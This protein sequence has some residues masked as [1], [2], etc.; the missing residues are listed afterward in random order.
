M[1]GPLFTKELLEMARRRRFF[2]VRVLIGIALLAGWWMG[3]GGRS[4][5]IEYRNIG[6]LSAIG[7]QLFRSWAYF[8]LW[9]VVALTPLLVGGLIAGEKDGRT[10][11]T[12]LT[13]LLTN[14]EILVGK[15]ASRLLLLCILI[16][17]SVPI[18][19]VASIYGGFDVVQVIAASAVI[20]TTCLFV[21]VVSLYY[22]AITF[23]PYIAML[24]A[25]FF[26]AMVWWLAPTVLE[27]LN[28]WHWDT[29]WKVL[30][31]ATEGKSDPSVQSFRGG[32]FVGSLT[33]KQSYSV[34]F[35]GTT[36]QITTAQLQSGATILAHLLIA[37]LLYLRASH[38][39]RVRLQPGKPPW[40]FTVAMRT[41]QSLV[42]A[43]RNSVEA[44]K[45]AAGWNKLWSAEE[46]SE[47][48]WRSG[49]EQTIESNPLL[50]RNR[51]A[52][53]F[54]PEHFVAAFQLLVGVGAIAMFL[55]IA[56]QERVGVNID[57]QMERIGLW[58]LVGTTILFLICSAI[59]A[60]GA[61]ARER[62]YGSWEVLML[63]DL[64]PG[65][66]FSAALLG[67]LGSLRLLLFITVSLV[68]V[69]GY[70]FSGFF[71]ILVWAVCVVAF[72]LLVASYALFTSLFH[73]RIA[74]AIASMAFGMVLLLVGPSM[75]SSQDSLIDS[76]PTTVIGVLAA[77]A[78][79][80]FWLARSGRSPWFPFHFLVTL[81]VLAFI[82]AVFSGDGSL[83]GNTS[84]RKL[85]DFYLD[86]R[87]NSPLVL[88]A[89]PMTWGRRFAYGL[90]ETIPDFKG[91]IAFSVAALA[92]SLTYLASFRTL[93][94]AEPGDRRKIR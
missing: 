1:F 77:L 5:T 35:Y 59:L 18:L 78:V 3:L 70:V 29:P 26:L 25:Y 31:V 75:V 76:Q 86:R 88:V 51:V 69:V 90:T 68:V 7:E 32:F 21:I 13:T 4:S 65:Q 20:A 61:F 56:W 71:P 36:L 52:N 41:Y 16:A 47:R 57:R 50:Y 87:A 44:R 55:F 72:W 81:T 83:L 74:A 53:A 94:A 38:L 80:S 62:Q 42:G 63:A 82:A 28:L 91:A 92:I 8:S 93:A 58:A 17:S 79:L 39:L 43:A 19:S 37:A 2:L 64:S 49:L 48:W 85:G 12:L 27:H 6:K 60:A 54:D 73:R 30:S 45:N 9:G 10:F 40:L 24:R 46:A 89:F 14:R 66:H 33:V 15:A 84:Y 34:P 11:E 67:V 22:S 23:K